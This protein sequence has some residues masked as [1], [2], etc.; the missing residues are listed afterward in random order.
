MRGLKVLD[1][2]LIVL[3]VFV[4]LSSV[5]AAQARQGF[6]F[7]PSPLLEQAADYLD[8]GKFLE[9]V[10]LYKQVA[11][12]A[13]T[14]RQQ[15]SA[16]VRMGDVLS[17]FLEKNKQA[18]GV[19]DRVIERF[20]ATEVTE[21]AYFNRAMVLYE[22]G[23]LGLAKQGFADY[24]RYFPRGNRRATAAFMDDQIA[25]E[26]RSTR[27]DQPEKPEPGGAVLSPSVRIR[28]ALGSFVSGQIGCPGGGT[29]QK[30]ESVFSGPALR[31]EAMGNALVVG[32]KKFRRR[33]VFIPANGF[34]TYKKKKYT[35]RA[36]FSI[37]K[38]KVL[39]V[40]ELPLEEYLR[41][42][43]PRE[44]IASWD[45]EALCSQAVAARTYA[46]YLRSKSQDKPYDVASTTAS[47]VYGGAGAATGATDRAVAETAG[48]VLTYNGSPVLSYFHSHSGGV[49][50]DPARVWTTGM[51]YYRIKDDA[52]SQ[53]FHPLDWSCRISAGEIQKILVKKGFHVGPVRSVRTIERSPSG[54][55]AKV[56]IGTDSGDV[57]VKGNTLRIWLGAGR[58]KST[59]GSI[60]RGGDG[61]LFKG[62][63]FGHGVGLSQWGAQG[64]ANSG[65]SYLDI[66]SHY[67]PGTTVTKKY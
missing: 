62:Q 31:V 8:Q 59:F 29:S 53:K 51:P 45:N 21:N 25:G 2:I 46:L 22:Q 56:R 40:N 11:R 15:A 12:Y 63:G 36:V 3:V 35:G 37:E 18:L 26:L 44:M 54:R 64:M 41:G 67:Y 1:G 7:D 28:V 47:Q 19:Y 43:V 9:C 23:R 10:E 30:K 65:S 66:L 61:F 33:C 39:L 24:V 55:W 13:P 5:R 52:V 58:I 49:L 34:F 38:N 48:Q 16:M 6:Y 4:L 42:V 17:L 57:E 20:G 32:G 60:T 27:P 14:A 50:E